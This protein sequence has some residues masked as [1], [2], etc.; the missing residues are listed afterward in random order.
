MGGRPDIRAA[1]MGTEDM[2]VIRLGCIER[3]RGGWSRESEMGG[4]SYSSTACA[5]DCAGRV[6]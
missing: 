2:K 3:G 5:N 6:P 4:R 1:V